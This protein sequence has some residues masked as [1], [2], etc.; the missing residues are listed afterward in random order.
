MGW[1]IAVTVAVTLVS[2]PASAADKVSRVEALSAQGDA[3]FLQGDYGE[4]LNRYR[5]AQQ[6]LSD[7]RLVWNLARCHEMLSELLAARS[8]YRQVADTTDDPGWR[9]DA[10]RKIARL[11]RRL[12]AP[13]PVPVRLDRRVIVEPSLDIHSG[14]QITSPARAGQW[15]L[16]GGG[17]AAGIL[18]GVFFALEDSASADLD[19]GELSVLD[20]QFREKDQSN[21]QN[22]TIAS[23]SV[24]GALLVSGIV[25]MIVDI[26]RDDGPA[27]GFAPTTDGGRLTFSTSF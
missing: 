6:I 14:P 17:I 3:L 9:W 19:S 7:V 25:W 4:A 8:L 5:H 13:V 11:S 26:K 18:G 22:A 20:R 1:L 2:M 10:R 23:F 27:M 24:S 21:F 12:R 16:I 15:T